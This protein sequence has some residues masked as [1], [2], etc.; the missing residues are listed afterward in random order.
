MDEVSQLNSTTRGLQVKLEAQLNVT[1]VEINHKLDT[2]QSE[3]KVR[4]KVAF[5]A[6]IASSHSFIGHVSFHTRKIVKFDKV[7]TNI[8]NAYDKKTG[9]FTAPVK[10]VYLFSFMTF[11]YN[12]YTSGA[13]LV[14]NG[15]YQVSTWE[16]KG[17]DT[18]DTTSNSVILEMNAGDCAN[19]ILWRGGKIYTSVFSGFLIFP[20]V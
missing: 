14:K 10:G 12:I 2:I 17:S 16:S 19:I 4:N 3:F 18:S 7:F 5:S 13:I 6:S 15:K 11:G 8:G 1:E 20:L 9:I